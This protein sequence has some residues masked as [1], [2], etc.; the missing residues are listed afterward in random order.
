LATGDLRI[1]LGRDFFDVRTDPRLL[2]N[3]VGRWEGQRYAAIVAERGPIVCLNARA[4]NVPMPGE[5]YPAIAARRQAWLAELDPARTALSSATA[6]R[7]A[8]CAGCSRTAAR[9]RA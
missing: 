9:S 3:E 1:G 5:Y 2:E 8:S 7:S 6:S 4:F